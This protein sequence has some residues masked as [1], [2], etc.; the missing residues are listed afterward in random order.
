[1]KFVHIQD[2][3]SNIEN[4]E[5]LRKETESLKG[6]IVSLEKEKGEITEKLKDNEKSLEENLNKKM[7][8]MILM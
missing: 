3:V 6:N 2:L 8:G 1:M 7:V 4:A 5:N